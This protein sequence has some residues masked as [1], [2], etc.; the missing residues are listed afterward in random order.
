MMN[1]TIDGKQV[2]ARAGMNLLAAARKAGAKVPSLCWMRGLNDIASCRVCLVEADGQLVASCNTPVREG[3]VVKTASL[4]VVAARRA[5]VAALMK[6]HRGECAACV[7][8][9]TCALR[10]LASDFNVGD[11]AAPVPKRGVWS[12]AFPLLRDSSKC[13]KCMRCVAECAKVQY[14][15]VW[16][17]TDAGAHLTVSVKGGMPIEQAGCALCGQCV[18][19]CPTGALAARDDTQKVMAALL[20]S[21]VVTVV[22]VAPAARTSWGEDVGVSREAA[23]PGRMVSALRALGFDYVFDTDFAA[24]LTI[25]EE[26]REFVEFLKSDKPRPMF[27]SCCPGW[28]RFV[29]QY[30]PRLVPRLSSA[31]SPHQMLGALVKNTLGADAPN[32]A[33]ASDTESA[34]GANSAGKRLFCV[35]V[36]PC[37]AKKYECDVPQ[38]AT[39]AGRDVDAVLTVREFCRMLK[40][41]RVDCAALGEGEFDNPLGASTGAGTIFGR[42]GGVMEAALRSAVFL[43]TGQNPDFSACDTTAATPDAPWVSKQLDVAGTPVRVAVASGLGNT[44]KLLDAIEAGEV[45][46]DFVEIMACPGGCVGGGGQPIAFNRELAKERAQVLNNLDAADHLR[47]SHENPYVQQLYK[48]WLGAPLSHTSHEWLHTDQESWDL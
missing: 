30:H 4:R 24:D 21:D 8:Q 17:P 36:M 37:V 43:T 45:S 15:A 47:Y 31:K 44:A 19:H 27:T 25:M 14:C 5:N 41:F 39:D 35:S 23:T 28:V 48:T 12:E 9:E 7:R 6:G 38:L 16:E 20:D 3:M 18:T 29:K 32:A 34:H 40:M 13:I 26:G 46:Y 11:S 42:T 2:Q 10:Q 22:Q 33:G 1:L